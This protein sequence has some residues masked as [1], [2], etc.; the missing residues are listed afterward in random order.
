MK[1]GT[2]EGTSFF[3]GFHDFPPVA[4]AVFGANG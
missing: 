2:P 3:I 1:C 4:G